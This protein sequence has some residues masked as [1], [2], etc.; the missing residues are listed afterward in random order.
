MTDIDKLFDKIPTIDYPDQPYNRIV[1][2]KD[3][4]IRLVRKSRRTDDRVIRSVYVP[5]EIHHIIRRVFMEFA[6]MNELNHSERLLVWDFVKELE[7]C[8]PDD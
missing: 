6:S 8:F 5:K 7:W 2:Y 3:K 4:P 1:G